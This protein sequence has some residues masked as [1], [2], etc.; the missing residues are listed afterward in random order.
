[1]AEEFKICLAGK[2]TVVE[3]T[4]SL[5]AIEDIELWLTENQIYYLENDPEK[6]VG[7]ASKYVVLP[8]DM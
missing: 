5:K 7:D 8:L 3:G 4:E 1:M 6:P 2:N